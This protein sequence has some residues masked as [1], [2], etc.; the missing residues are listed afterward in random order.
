MK[1]HGT[2]SPIITVLITLLI[3]PLKG[4]IGVIPIISRVISYKPSYNWLV[5]TMN[6]QVH[7]DQQDIGVQGLRDLGISDP[8]GSSTGKPTRSL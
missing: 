8:D 7:Y 1:V 5:S 3:I 4:L 2:Y 6:L